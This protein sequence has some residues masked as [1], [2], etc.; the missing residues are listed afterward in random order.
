VIHWAYDS[1]ARHSIPKAVYSTGLKTYAVDA[2]YVFRGW[3]EN[4]KAEV[5]YETNNPSKG[6]VYKWW[7]Y[8][9]T[10]GEV[11]GSILLILALFQIAVSVTKNPTAEA[12]IEQL[13]YKEEKKTKYKREDE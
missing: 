1:A 8:W 12:L 7:G 5:I 10:W 4:D 3:K 11:L 2:R 9:I 13:E 6:A